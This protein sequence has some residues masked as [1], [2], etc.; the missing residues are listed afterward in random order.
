MKAATAVKSDVVL[1]PETED[2]VRIAAAV[3]LAQGPVPAKALLDVPDAELGKLLKKGIA[4]VLKNAQFLFNTPS[5]QHVKV[6]PKAR[7][8][9]GYSV[10]VPSTGR[11]SSQAKSK[12]SSVADFE[13]EAISGRL[14]LV[15]EGLLLAPAAMW[16]RLGVTRQALS[17]AQSSGRIFTV[18]VGADQYYPAFY[19]SEKLDRRKLEAVT[20]LLGDLPG[21]SKWQFFTTAKAS[22]EN[23]SP[24]EALE[25]GMLE[26]VKDAAEAFAE[27]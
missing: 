5:F 18:D 10:S 22:L 19:L 15:K 25:R 23:I 13:A 7:K 17:K 11:V 1:A 27:R 12:V 4:V 14:R 9:T 26:Q 16:E 21:W 20:K 24:L 3:A 6:V 2:Y 8:Q